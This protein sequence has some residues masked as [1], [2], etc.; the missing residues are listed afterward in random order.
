[1]AA[2]MTGAED[3]VV[4][5]PD[6]MLSRHSLLDPGECEEICGR[7]P[8]HR[9]LERDR[10]PER[11]GTALVYGRAAY[12]DATPPQS[13]PEVDYHAMVAAENRRLEAML[14]DLY[15]RLLA[16]LEELLGEPAAY[17]PDLLA[18]PGL[19]VFRGEGIAVASAS[20]SHFD[21]QDRFLRLP[22]EREEADPISVTLPLRLPAG[23][24][25]LRFYGLTYAEFLEAERTQDSVSVDDLATGKPCFYEDYEVGT[26]VVQRGLYL[27]GIAAPSRR[28][29]A[30]EERITLQCHGIKAG[31]AYYIYW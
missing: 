24:S 26:M 18:L 7:L 2:T 21:I 30:A 6:G 10:D 17:A 3:V 4:E 16:K 13:D 5:G 31:G 23:G 19:H 22:G 15:P 14:G 1:V 11:P 27:H 20:H 25:G 8:E 29:E 12:I 9:H 28:Y